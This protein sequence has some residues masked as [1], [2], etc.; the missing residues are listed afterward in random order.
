MMLV[1][2]VMMVVVMVFMMLV[3]LMM[4][5]V[6]MML[7]VHMLLVAVFDLHQVAAGRRD[8]GKGSAEGD[9]G[10]RDRRECQASRDDARGQQGLK[11]SLGHCY[12]RVGFWFA[13]RGSPRGYPEESEYGMAPCLRNRRSAWNIL[14]LWKEVTFSSQVAGWFFGVPRLEKVKILRHYI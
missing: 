2:V 8:V 13:P 6:V 12:L 7:V 11:K 4:M 14:K 1:I 10:M 5:M 3:V 9:A